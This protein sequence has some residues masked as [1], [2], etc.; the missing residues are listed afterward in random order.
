MIQKELLIELSRQ[1][2]AGTLETG[3]EQVIDP[4]MRRYELCSTNRLRQPASAVERRSW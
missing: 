3:V 4:D 2:I 1:I